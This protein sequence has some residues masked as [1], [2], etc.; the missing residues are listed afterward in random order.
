MLE[1]HPEAQCTMYLSEQSNSVYAMENKSVNFLKIVLL[2]S[3][4][5][6][7]EGDFYLL[8]R[9]MIGCRQ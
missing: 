4:K 9:L 1:K 6:Q 3:E 7:N 8:I 5:Y 2:Q